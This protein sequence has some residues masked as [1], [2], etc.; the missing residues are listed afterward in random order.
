[1]DIKQINLQNQVRLYDIGNTI[2]QGELPKSHFGDVYAVR[3]NRY[4][5][6]LDKQVQIK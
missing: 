2:I 5:D 6:E 4:R 3:Q 1:M